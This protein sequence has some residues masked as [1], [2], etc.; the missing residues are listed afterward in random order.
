MKD[1]MLTSIPALMHALVLSQF[2]GQFVLTE[3][4]I[5]AAAEGQVLVRIKASGVNP[6]D[7]KIRAGLVPD[8]VGF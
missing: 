4:A 2:N 1:E 6:L 3:S 7:T 8:I 5:P